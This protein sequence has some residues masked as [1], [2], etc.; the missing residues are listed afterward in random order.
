MRPI[1]LAVL[2]AAALG[3]GPSRPNLVP[4]IAPPEEQPVANLPDSLRPHNWGGGS[5]VH[6]SLI[7]QLQWCNETEVAQL[8]RNVFS[9][10]ETA[11][12]IRGKL[13][14][15]GFDYRFTERA[16]PAF[17]DWVTATRRSALIWYFPNHCVAFVGWGRVENREV[18]ILNDNNRPGH[19]I[20]I[21]KQTFLRNWRDYGGFGLSILNPPAPPIPWPSLVPPTDASR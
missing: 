14:K 21:P 16:D 18:A 9:G 3:C 1:I 2:A 4:G 12:G 13:D 20:T 10:G 6:A 19:F 5:C 17:L 15:A 8:W 7:Y 11:N